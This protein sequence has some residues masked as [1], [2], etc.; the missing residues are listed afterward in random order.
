MLINQR[1]KIV[2]NV[3]I[4][5]AD[6][7]KQYINLELFVGFV[8]G[9]PVFIPLAPKFDLSKQQFAM[10]MQALENLSYLQEMEDSTNK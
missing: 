10:F 6:N 7:G 5:T 1:K 2:C 4:I 3:N 8:S 9:K